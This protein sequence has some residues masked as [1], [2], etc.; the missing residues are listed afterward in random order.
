VR[1][2]SELRSAFH[3]SI[4]FGVWF[5]AITFLVHETLGRSGLPLETLGL[6]WI[7]ALLCAKFV[8]LGQWLLPM[9]PLTRSHFWPVLLPRSV[10]YLLVVVVL[11]V[12]EEGLKGLIHG[13]PFL[14]AM[15]G[16]AGGN[17]I[18]ALSLAL[19]YW[20]ILISY[21]VLAGFLDGASEARVP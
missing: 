7:K 1:L 19:V 13:E 21:L 2:G 14:S 15:S 4:Y 12:L 18:H 6:V 17:P 20:L 11:S 9:K 5:S 10:V 8:L 16:Y 3:L